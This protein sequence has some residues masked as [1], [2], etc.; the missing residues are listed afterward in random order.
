MLVKVVQDKTNKDLYE[1]RRAFACQRDGKLQL[2][3]E[4]GEPLV[5]TFEPTKGLEI[6]AMNDRGQTV[7]RLFPL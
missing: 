1:C 2:T 6:Y 4:N 5:L 3:I 7:D